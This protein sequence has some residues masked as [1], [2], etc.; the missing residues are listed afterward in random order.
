MWEEI[1]L[2]NAKANLANIVTESLIENVNCNINAGPVSTPERRS[3]VERFFGTLEE[4]SFHR[5]PSTTGSNPNDPRRKDSEKNAIR[6]EVSVSEIEE[7][8]EIAIANYNN[9]EHTG[10]GGFTPL[11]LMKQRIDRGMIPRVVPEEERDDL[12]ICCL[13]V[14][15]TIRGNREKSIYPHITYEGVVY[16]SNILVKSWHMVGQKLTLLVNINDLRTVEAYLEDGSEFGSLSAKD[17]WG[18]KPHTLKMRK[19]INNLKRNKK[20]KL[21]QYDDP[22]EIY[23]DYLISRFEKSKSSRNKLCKLNRIQEENNNDDIIKPSG[24]TSFSNEACNNEEKNQYKSINKS[25]IKD[26]DNEKIDELRNSDIFR[27]L[28]F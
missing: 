1:L 27:T 16:K 5:L 15:R 12:K 11:D 25:K 22:I 19:E 18:I 13:K 20:I 2:D 23:N 7:I 17:K 24:N 14:V 6:Y 28:N 4:K 26:S 10:I 21:G 3:I 9:T 8:V